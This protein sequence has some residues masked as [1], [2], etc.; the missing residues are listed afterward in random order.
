MAVPA[1]TASKAARATTGC[2]AVSGTTSSSAARGA[3]R[4]IGHEGADSF[5]FDAAVKNKNLDDVVDFSP[6]EDL[7]VLKASR[8][9]GVGDRLGAAELHVGAAASTATHRIIYNPANGDLIYDANGNAA[10]GAQAFRQAGDGPRSRQRRFRRGRLE[11]PA[12]AIIWK[13]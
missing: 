10:G 5:R 8:F 3:D 9:A 12:P 1:T 6:G 2:P 11:S 13:A 4:L 7:M